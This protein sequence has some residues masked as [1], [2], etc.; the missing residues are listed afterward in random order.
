MFES[1]SLQSAPHNRAD[2]P[3]QQPAAAGVDQSRLDF[4]LRHLIRCPGVFEAGLAML[5]SEH[6]IVPDEE[7]YQAAWAATVA[8]YRRND[9]PPVETALLWGTVD[10]LAK[11]REDRFLLGQDSRIARLISAILADGDDEFSFNVK[12]ALEVLHAFVEEREG[13]E[14]PSHDQDGRHVEGRHIDRSA[15]EDN[16]QGE[17]PGEQAATLAEAPTVP[18]S[19]ALTPRTL[20]P[21]GVPMLDGMMNGGSQA[22]DVNV[23][24]GPPNVGKTALGVQIVVSAGRLAS[25][26]TDTDADRLHVHLSRARDRESIHILGNANAARVK[27]SRLSWPIEVARLSTT[28]DLLEYDHELDE[29]RKQILPRSGRRDC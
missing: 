17:M 19:R 15:G 9:W 14:H 29:E 25:T 24:L 11:S 23:I 16:Q 22:G 26:S 20:I 6:F 13:V 7:I 8:C 5:K 18:E 12:L 4:L 2:N 10:R 1:T 28:D 21:T 27:V 3:C